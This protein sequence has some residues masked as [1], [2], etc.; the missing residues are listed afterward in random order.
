MPNE[1]RKNSADGRIN[2]DNF[3]C[4]ICGYEDFEWGYTTG[5]TSSGFQFRAYSDAKF[6]HGKLIKARECMRCG[7][8]QFFTRERGEQ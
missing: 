7:N 1:K 5:H 6:R 4:P 2:P 8:L 3:P